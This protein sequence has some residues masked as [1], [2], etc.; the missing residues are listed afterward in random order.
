M[1]NNS[2]YKCFYFVDEKQRL[3]YGSRVRIRTTWTLAWYTTMGTL[4]WV[5]YIL[6][7]MGRHGG[8]IG[9]GITIHFTFTLECQWW[10]SPNSFLMF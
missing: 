3:T 7:F 2:I 8:T 6:F 1:Q 4:P 9:I 10:S 5:H